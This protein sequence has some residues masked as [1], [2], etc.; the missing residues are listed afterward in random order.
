VQAVEEIAKAIRALE[1][2]SAGLLWDLLGA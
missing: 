2:F 1:M